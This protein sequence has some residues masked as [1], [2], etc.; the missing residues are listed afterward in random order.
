MADID[1]AQKPAGQSTLLWAL[2]AIVAVGGLMVWLAVQSHRTTTAVVVQETVEERDRASQ[3]AR[4]TVTVEL[5][6]L[7]ANPDGHT[8]RDVETVT[9]IAA[10]LGARAYWADIPGAN[11]FLVVLTEGAAVDDLASGQTITV[12]GLVVEVTEALVDQWIAEGAINE[13][14]RAEAVFASHA[15]LADEAIR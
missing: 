4:P 1:V 5:S 6:E 8:G 14:S 12:A 13:G 15:I 7:G 11:P 3:R 10:T 9:P 2:L